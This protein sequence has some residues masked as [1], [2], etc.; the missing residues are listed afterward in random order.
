MEITYNYKVTEKEVTDII[1]EITNIFMEVTN[2]H[3]SNKLSWK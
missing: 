3:G 1:M 2:Y